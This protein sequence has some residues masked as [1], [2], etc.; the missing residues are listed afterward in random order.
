VAPRLTF[1]CDFLG[2][3]CA[4]LRAVYRHKSQ[5]SG[6]HSGTVSE[7]SYRKTRRNGIWKERIQKTRSKNRA[8][9]SIIITR[10]TNS[11]A[12]RNSASHFF[13]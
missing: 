1:F 8:D 13:R 11:Q 7:W 10:R 6:K 9:A 4:F 5:Q 12:A 2:K 3:H